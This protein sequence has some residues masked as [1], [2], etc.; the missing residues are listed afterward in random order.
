MSSVPAQLLFLS[1]LC[2]P[3][4]VIHPPVVLSSE[5][6]DEG[7]YEGDGEQVDV[8]GTSQPAQVGYPRLKVIFQ[9][10]GS[11]RRKVG[12]LRIKKPEVFWLRSGVF[13]L[14]LHGNKH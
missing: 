14:S 10:P 11:W 5:E 13:D 9:E 6:E 2:Q 1:A 12:N 7:D 3:P 4:P 8:S